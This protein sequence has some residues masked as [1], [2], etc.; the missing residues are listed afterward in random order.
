MSRCE[1][2]RRGAIH[3]ARV[4]LPLVVSCMLLTAII[5]PTGSPDVIDWDYNIPITVTREWPDFD[6]FDEEMTEFMGAR[7]IPGGALAVSRNGRVVLARGYGY[8]DVEAKELVRPTSLFRIASVSKPLTAVAVLRLLEQGEGDVTLDT[9]AFELLDY[10]PHLAPDAQ[11]DPRVRQIT[12]RHLLRHTAGWD[13]EQTFDPMGRPHTIA[14]ELGVTPPASQADIIR[15]M[16]GQPLQHDPGTKH[17]YSNF[18]YCVLGRI[19][20]KLSGK[21]YEQYVQDEILRPLGITDMRI[22]RTLP[23]QRAPGEVRYY[24]PGKGKNVMT[25][26]ED[27]EVPRPDGGFHLEAMDSHGGWI[28]SAVDLVR[29]ACAFDDP[30]SCPL[31]KPESIAEMFAR[32]EGEAGFE[33]DGKPKAAYYGLGWSVRPKGEGKANHWHGGGLAG[34]KSLLVRRHDGLNWAVVFNQSRDASGRSYDEID[35]ALHRGANA[36]EAWPEDGLFDAVLGSRTEAGNA[37]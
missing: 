14:R 8:A 21:T 25:P 26:G 3:R 11:P 2:A 37:E 32:P 4:V 12:I 36:V 23:D 34:T 20:E 6:S 35:P 27:D 22:G 5:A 15:Y 9:R 28:A 16:L 1:Q 29:F 18:G 13:R 7:N 33:P 24:D 19:I 10:E 31:L 17:A 30:E